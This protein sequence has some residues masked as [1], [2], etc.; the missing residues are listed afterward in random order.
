MAAFSGYCV[1][2]NGFHWPWAMTMDGG[3]FDM[4]GSSPPEQ[5]DAIPLNAKLQIVA[6]VGAR[7]RPVLSTEAYQPR[8]AS[9]GGLLLL[10]V[11]R[12]SSRAISRARRSGRGKIRPLS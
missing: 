9:R 6:F 2:S 3:S 7:R 12:R 11:E 8:R 10:L 5:W 1:Q 4:A